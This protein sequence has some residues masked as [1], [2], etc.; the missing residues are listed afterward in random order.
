PAITLATEAAIAS[1]H[2]MRHA[3]RAATTMNTAMMDFRTFDGDARTVTRRGALI[4]LACLSAFAALLAAPLANAQTSSVKIAVVMSRT[5]P[6]APGGIPTFDAI[7]L[8][9]DEANAT[10][11]TPRIE[12]VPYDDRST[13]D[14]A[15]E[16]AGAIIAG[17][18]LVVVGPGTT[19]SALAAGP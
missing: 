17:D 11:E 8:A 7:R 9:V 19:T 4:R 14:G 18:A 15:R 13:D 2:D 3:T 12:L 10:G 16:A 5:G 6:G 1:S